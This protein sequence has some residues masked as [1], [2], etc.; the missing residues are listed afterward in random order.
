MNAKHKRIAASLTLI[1]VKILYPFLSTIPVPQ[2]PEVLSCTHFR[3]A[4]ISFYKVFTRFLC[5]GMAETNCWI[6]TKVTQERQT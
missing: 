5:Q 2:S 3:V 1:H 6:W 4:S